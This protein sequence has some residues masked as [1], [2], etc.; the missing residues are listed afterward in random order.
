MMSNTCDIHDACMTCGATTEIGFVI[1]EGDDVADV[2]ITATTAA[3]CQAEWQNYLDLAKSVNDK[4]E[5]EISPQSNDSELHARLRFD[6]SAEKLIFEL[7]S[8]SLAK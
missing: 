4:V 2:N 7:K 1:K 6:C 8:R 5:F 3:A